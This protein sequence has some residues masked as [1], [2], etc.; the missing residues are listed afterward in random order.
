MLR[1][2][3]AYGAAHVHVGAAGGIGSPE[4]AAAAFLLGA[5]FL[6]TG[7]INQC[8]PE[9]A[10]SGAVKD[11]L[12]GLAPHD[13]DP[14]PA[15]DLFE[16]GVRANVVKRGVFLPAGAA[17]LQ[18]LWRAHESPSA[19]DP[20]VREEVESRILRCPVEEA[21]AG[22]AA[23]LR[24]LSPES[25]VGEHDPKHRLALALRSYL[26]TG[27]ESAVRGEVERRVDH[28]VFCGSAMGACNSWL[29]GTDLA[30]WQ[31]R[32]VADLTER[33][34]AKAGELLARYTERLDRSRRAVHL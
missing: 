4:A 9:A 17:R 23:R 26:E 14:A 33:L 16:W 11:L 15:P 10:T 31:R 2:R 7:S 21:A 5:E 25:A 28:L 30:P 32:H 22:A 24:A 27:F 13:V 18:E 20:A 12:Q 6:V 3:E 19:L 1:L 8:T 29:A 34:L